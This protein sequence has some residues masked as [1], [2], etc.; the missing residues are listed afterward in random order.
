MM[1]DTLYE[2]LERVFAKIMGYVNRGDVVPIAELYFCFT[3]SD[4]SLHPTQHRIV[5]QLSDR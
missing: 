2:E 3:A 1:E 5:F 4:I